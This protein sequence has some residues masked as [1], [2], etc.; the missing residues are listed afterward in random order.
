MNQV[1]DKDLAMLPDFP[2]AKSRARRT[3]TES[4][5]RRI[6]E[7]APLLSQIAH[8]RVHEGKT[9]RL[10]RGDRSE[11]RIEFQ[12]ARAELEIPREQMRSITIEELLQHITV[13]AEQFAGQHMNLM[14]TRLNEAVESV[15]NSVS[16][17][18]LG[19]RDAFLEAQRRLE[20]DFDPETLEPKNQ[21][22]VLHP[23]QVESFMAQAREWEA[24][25]S[26]LEEF[27]CI[28]KQQLEDWRARENCR[29]LVD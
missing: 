7:H 25:P 24:D 15:G 2:E 13:M 28:R 9:T 26:F 18:E 20:V 16:A 19:N 10:T 11:D 21:T 3:F 22:L 14:F 1:I 4:V 17:A 27:D 8:H 12:E 5:R 29:Q 23:D 6:T